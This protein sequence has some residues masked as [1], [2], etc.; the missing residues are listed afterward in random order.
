M[1]K[2][3]TPG[4]KNVPETLTKATSSF[5]RNVFLAMLALGSF[6][7]VYT[8]LMIWFGYHAI[9]LFDYGINQGISPFYSIVAGICLG[10][11]SIFMLKS[12][13]IFK[14]KRSGE[15]FELK[16]QDE[17]EL[18]DYIHKLAEEVGAPK[19]H[20]IILTARVNASV[21]YDLS[22]FNLLIPSKKNLEIG[23]G[24]INVLNLGEL[25]AVLAH[26]FGHFAQRSMLLGRYVYT[27]QQIAERV[28]NK[29]DALDKI[30]RGISSFDIRIAWIGWIIS[31]LVWAI[32]AL[33]E[34]LFSVVVY[35]E[36]ALSREMEFQA[37][38]VAVSVT[39]SDAL[40]H[41]LHKL[42]AADEG[43]RAGID[44]LNTL[45]N[46]KQAAP[47][48]FALQANYIEKTRWILDDPMYGMSPVRVKTDG[49]ERVFKS[50]LVN[51]PEMWATHPADLDREENAKSVYLYAD[52]DERSAWV[53]FSDSEK[54]RRKITADLIQ[55]AG[56]KTELIEEEESIRV[57]NAS[58][59]D[60]TFLDP[61]YKGTYLNRFSFIN[62]KTPDEIYTN[63]NTVDLQEQMSKMYPETLKE[64]LE[65]HKE[66]Q[67][68]IQQLTIVQHEVLT[69]ERRMIMHRGKQIKRRQIPDIIK[70][71]KKEEKTLRQELTAHDTLCRQVPYSLVLEKK[72]EVA[73]YLKSVSRLVHYAE[74]SLRNIDDVVGKFHN[75]LRV[76]TADGRVT[77]AEMGDLL[78]DCANLGKALRPLYEQSKNITVPTAIH[79]KL[80]APYEA[81][82][83]DYKLGQADRQNIN[84]WVNNAE[85]W[86]RQAQF[87]L[88]KMR[89]AAL[90]HLLDTEEEILRANKA[91]TNPAVEAEHVGVVHE[92]AL[93]MPGS[94]RK[95][96]YKLGLWDRFI[97]GD[98]LVPTAAKFM[99]SAG[100]IFIAIWASN[101]DDRYSYDDDFY[102]DD[103]YYSNADVYLY[104]GFD[105]K[106]RVYV[107]GDLTILRPGADKKIQ[108]SEGN[109][110]I[111]T[112]TEEGELIERFTANVED[113][114]MEYVYNA[115]GAGYFMEYE[116]IYGSN[117]S[118]TVSDQEYEYYGLDRWF[119]TSADYI[120]EDPPPSIQTYSLGNIRKDVL[121]VLS[122]VT[123]QELPNIWEP[124]QKTRQ[125]IKNHVIFD[126]AD[127]PYMLYWLALS[128]TFDPDGQLAFDRLEEN[129]GEVVFVRHLQDYLEGDAREDLLAKYQE[130]ARSNPNNPDYYYLN[131]RV[132]ENE[133]LQ[134]RQFIAGSKK[135]PEHGWLAFA[136]GY[137][138]ANEEQWDLA[139]DRYSVALDQLPTLRES[140]TI[141]MERCIRMSARKQTYMLDRSLYVNDE[142]E[143]L[144][145]LE[146]GSLMADRNM[147]D[148]AYYMLSNGKL[149]ESMQYA[150]R[151]T[152]DTY[153][154]FYWYIAASEGASETVIQS[155]LD[156]DI[157]ETVHTGNVGIALGLLARYERPY[158]EVIDLFGRAK[159]FDETEIGTVRQFILAVKAANYSRAE[160]LINSCT[161]F[162]QKMSLRLLGVVLSNKACPDNWIVMSKK[163]LF[164]T[165][166]PYFGS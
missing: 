108:L 44:A 147:F 60:W 67:E 103:E 16:R 79:N 13:F 20:K 66:V 33:I 120:M 64:L 87:A 136:S 6:I 71:L 135:W 142:V 83:E 55:T 43:Y 38:K 140:M 90:E 86:V 51:P 8:G 81:Y 50:R 162:R 39:G 41:A 121:A 131:T 116:V 5:K 111:R 113:Y 63:L 118:A 166:R 93:L 101:V 72:P 77:D 149:T 110:V 105:R 133:A 117:S 47:D 104:N 22:I 130:L 88:N 137:W 85:S 112:T 97:S 19:P 151:F 119:E 17:P 15:D 11:L 28:V 52:I 129:P 99:A 10:M 159:G 75:T 153:R 48:L 89:N 154:P 84:D 32:R 125:A 156:N 26:E 100:L 127:S 62:V 74:H 7:L 65:K 144:R 107:D 126:P 58:D 40:I 12:L 96:Q 95:I 128:S 114:F 49:S 152:R 69:A 123:P 30:I 35:A 73:A 9:Q 138:Y 150:R 76:V 98:G 134:N 14:S 141:D 106:V 145:S 31:I 57:M 21:F 158:E 59:Y 29:R 42:R 157:S 24:L 139:V 161:D 163:M 115:G 2:F 3:Y 143:N 92:Y 37:D 94:E 102:Y 160:S 34:V 27:A 53:L 61:K 46:R 155:A 91:K 25:K 68:E 80:G 164:V 18:F 54:L 124:D 45:I 132:I 36:R 109:H 122:D 23:L 148:N 78:R 1:S 56:V 82:F 4:P 146:K 165:E 70:E